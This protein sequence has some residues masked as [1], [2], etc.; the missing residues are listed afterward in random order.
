MRH[1]PIVAIAFTLALA[2]SQTA[3]AQST[4]NFESSATSTGLT[5]YTA[6]DSGLTLTL[7][8]PGST[9][10]I[11]GPITAPFGTRTLS[12]FA[13]ETSATSFLASFSSTL[14]SF[15]LNFGD[16]GADSDLFTL[17]A[18]S[19]ANGTGSVVGTTNVNY[20]LGS[21][22]GSIGTAS[23][24]GSPFQSVSFIG[25]STG[26]PNSVYYDNFVATVTGAVPE[27]A[28]WAMMLIGFG[29][30]GVAMRRRRKLVAMAQPA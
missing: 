18:F 8:R 11:V 5:T 22:P 9:F 6:T 10:D 3:H 23:F 28:T 29:A 16:F 27:P 17:T 25:G 2:G 12:P 21:L 4:F 15:S 24:T 30:I 7:T 20:G 26:F 1:T 13:N 19:G 14:S